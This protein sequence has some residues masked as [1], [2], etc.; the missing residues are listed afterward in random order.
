M[1]IPLIAIA[2]LTSLHGHASLA[3]TT[4]L[5]QHQEIETIVMPHSTKFGLAPD[6]V[7]SDLSE[8]YYVSEQLGIE[9]A[10]PADYVVI[11]EQGS[12]A[13]G[14]IALLR[15]ED[16]GTSEPPII[17]IAFSDNPQQ[18]SLQAFRD[19]DLRMQVTQDHDNTTI[20]GQRALDFDATGYYLSRNQVFNTPDGRYV[21]YISASY[22]GDSDSDETEP[23]VEA[24]QVIQNSW[25]WR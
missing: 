11:S 13:D 16:V 10:Y 22:L 24:A 2:V 19:D 9:F 3:I 18:L 25:V 7:R 15:L 8:G 5:E 1:K 23:L 20:A 12:L 4:Y 6:L 21:I 17:Y 14:A